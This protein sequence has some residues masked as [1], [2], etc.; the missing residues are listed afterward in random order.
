[1]TV[2]AVTVFPSPDTHLD[3]GTPLRRHTSDSVTYT[4]T[5]KYTRSAENFDFDSLTWDPGIWP[6]GCCMSLQP[7]EKNAISI[8]FDKQ[9]WFLSLQVNRSFCKEVEGENCGPATS[10]ISTVFGPVFIE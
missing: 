8:S 2:T 5:L 4:V 6:D 7:F 9:D 3:P 10:S 1:M